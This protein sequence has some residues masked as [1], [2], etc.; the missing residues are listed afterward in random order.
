MARVEPRPSSPRTWTRRRLLRAAA[1]AAA[2]GSLRGVGTPRALAAPTLANH[3]VTVTMN[4]IFGS[5]DP[6]LRVL[7][8]LTQE[9]F[10]PF[11]AENPG[12]RVRITPQ[13]SIPSIL[14]GTS[15]DIIWDWQFYPYWAGHLLLP[16]DEYLKR[17]N[18]DTSIWVPGQMALF[19]RPFG[20][21]MLGAYAS[22]FVYAILLDL[23]DDL[24]LDYPSPDWTYQDFT[25]LAAALTTT[26]TSGQK[27]YGAAIPW[28]T[29]GLDGGNGQ[30]TFLLTAFGGGLTNPAGTRSWLDQP[31][32]LAAG[33]WI[34]EDLL[35]R[36]IAV[37]W[38]VFW[39]GSGNGLP[40]GNLAMDFE[41]G[42]S[43]FRL[44]EQLAGRKWTFHPFPIFPKG[45]FTFLTN[46]FWGIVRTTRHPEEAW[47]V[48]RWA[49][50]DPRFQEARMHFSALQPTL[51]SLWPKWQAIVEA[52]APPLQGKGLEWFV[53]AAVNGY[54]LC[55]QPY[56]DEGVLVSNAVANALSPLWNRQASVVEAFTQAARVADA[57]LAQGASG[58][59]AL[60]GRATA[61]HAATPP[62]LRAPV[63]SWP[64]QPIVADQA[65]DVVGGSASA[66]GG[67]STASLR[68]A[69]L[70]D[71]QH[72]YLNAEVTQNHPYTQPYSGTDMWKGD[73]LWCYFDTHP[74]LAVG[75]T[76]KV[77]LA[78]T[79]AGYQCW[80]TMDN[81]FP[82][83]PMDLEVL[84]HGWRLAAALPWTLVGPIRPAPGALLGFNAGVGW[85]AHGQGGFFDLNGQNPDQPGTG[86]LVTLR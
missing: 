18:V 37:P 25:R 80:N 82:T 50:T 22:P 68:V 41:W 49:T 72:L 28:Y 70:W 5:G 13:D 85:T 33:R 19:Q 39:A 12:I 23:F 56:A 29:N 59:V 30:P 62:S 20:T 14:A 15:S 9:A 54:A 86:V 36:G 55:M 69:L 7:T 77:G 60:F 1:A 52:V 71:A 27:R 34:Y 31:G 3:P 65:R 21:Y 58:P 8:A 78:K 2:A 64:T 6:N 44:A 66:W 81:S 46:D 42:S 45:R 32:S 24:G 47:R 40:K 51:K 48:L 43:P 10:A 57:I 63:G 16:L 73:M 11:E 61:A 84:P 76:G 75:N 17:D 83:V 35:W 74:A 53:D 26:S 4:G 67:P 38:D 79:P